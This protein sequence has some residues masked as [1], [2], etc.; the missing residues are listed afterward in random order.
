MWAAVC[1]DGWIV[2]DMRGVLGS[3]RWSRITHRVVAVIL[4]TT[5]KNC[6]PGLRVKVSTVSRLTIP[7]MV[8]PRATQ[9]ARVWRLQRT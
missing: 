3:W 9:A 2:L 8:P 1:A 5:D 7:A 6:N 4:A